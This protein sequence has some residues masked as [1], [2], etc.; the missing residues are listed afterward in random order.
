MDRPHHEAR[1]E[2]I[3]GASPVLAEGA[4]TEPLAMPAPQA[5]QSVGPEPDPWA[6]PP[7]V[8]GISPEPI[9]GACPE[10]VEG[11]RPEPVEG[12]HETAAI[13]P[14]MREADYAALV[15]DIRERGQLEAI[16]TWNGKVIDGRHRL[17][18]CKELGLTPKTREWDGQGS[19]LEFVISV[20]LRRRHLKENQRAMVAARMLPHFEAEVQK[21]E[22]LR[23]VEGTQ[24]LS[25]E[26][27]PEGRQ[28]REHAG[29]CLNISGRSVSRACIVLQKGV[30]ELISRVDQGVI[31]VV[32]AAKIAALPHPEQL[33]LLALSKSEL[34]KAL[35]KPV[36][37]PAPRRK[38]SVEDEPEEHRRL[39]D[40]FQC[41]NAQIRM[42][43]RG[44]VVELS[45]LNWRDEAVTI[46]NAEYLQQLL[47]RGVYF[48]RLL[49]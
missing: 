43:E 9:D 3:E 19:L 40:R 45:E 1:H 39:L 12:V 20:N 8:R 18:A 36:P 6:S 27:S 34:A 37:A 47:D 23:K 24:D 22:H 46:A 28:A 41:L 42:H 38:W 31:T 33:R 21:K 13:F 30:P 26:S 10:P 35:R 29:K 25:P 44:F 17:R 15:A 16:W 4:R 11:A 2:L 7:P 49:A 5:Q 14:L 48:T 32:P